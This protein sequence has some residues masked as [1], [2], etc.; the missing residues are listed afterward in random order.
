MDIN[1]ELPDW[2]QFLDLLRRKEK[3][4]HVSKVLTNGPEHLA[5]VDVGPVPLQKIPGSGDIF[6][7]RLLR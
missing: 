4:G 6:G 3:L 2:S 7:N 5:G 1:P